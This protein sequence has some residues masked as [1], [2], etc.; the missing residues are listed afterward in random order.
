MTPDHPASDLAI[1]PDDVRAA[2]RRIAGEVHLT[3]VLTSRLIDRQAGRS[4]F[5]KCENLQRGGAFKIRGATNKIHSLSEDERRRG[6]VA[7]SSGNHA[8]AVAL[9]ALA[10]GVDATIAMP[11]DAPRAKI[12]ATRGYGAT[13]VEYDRRTEDRRVVARRI[14]EA[15][16]KTIVPPY[17]DPWIMAGQGTAALELLDQVP[18]LGAIVVPV[19]G[20]GLL[21]GTAT[22]AAGEAPGIAVWGAEP[23]AADDTVR[24]LETGERVE[25]DPPDT[26]ADGARTR[27]P[28]ELTFPVVR[29]RAAGVVRVPDHALVRTMA[30]LLSRMKVLV[31]PTGALA[32]AVAIEGGVQDLPDRV[33][34]LLSGG[35]VDLGRSPGC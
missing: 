33:G 4:L 20:G 35:N 8:Q 10:A 29:A 16:G 32:A 9:A 7:Y 12:E 14:A 6:V 19:G 28:G 11:T 34:I 15:E 31:E 1:D 26:I 2:G 23:A 3:P 27:S 24:S 17:D 18:D 5:F 30:L 13:I 25:I 22:A 21:A